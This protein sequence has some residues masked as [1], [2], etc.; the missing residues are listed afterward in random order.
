MSEAAGAGEGRAV[1]ECAKEL[2]PADE[3]GFSFCIPSAAGKGPS[4]ALRAKRTWLW[5][6]VMETPSLPVYA[7]GAAPFKACLRPLWALDGHH[8]TRL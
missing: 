5:A 6:L 1:H 3:G 7:A 8:Q 2:D 4:L